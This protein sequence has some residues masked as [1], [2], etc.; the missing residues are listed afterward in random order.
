MRL[1]AAQVDELLRPF[2]LHASGFELLAEG[3]ANTNYRVRLTDGA[4]VVLR[5]HLR[6]PKAAR[7]E[8]VA[9]DR[10]AGSLPVA[11]VLYLDPERAISIVE[12]REGVSMERLL[13]EGRHAEVVSA[14]YDLG[15]S[16]AR[17][18]HFELPTAGFLDDQLD[19]VDPWP[20]AVD[21]LL[22]YLRFLLT[23]P[24]AAGRLGA[25]LV[26]AIT[27]VAARA[28][29]PLRAHSGPPCLVHGD[30]KPSNLLLHEGR[31]SAVLDWEFAHAGTW[32]FHL[33]QLFRHPLPDGFL[34]RFESGL[35]DG[36]RRLPPDWL[37]LVAALDMVNLVDFAT[38]ENAGERLVADARRLLEATVARWIE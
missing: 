24:L 3:K 34:A 15:M 27:E 26:A 6:E 1:D 20:S 22:G 32:L 18:S 12:W 9:V 31:L 30:Y 16:V 17:I 38:G 37:R 28:E 8:A 19:V 36:G 5:L 4:Q 14:A 13:A 11:R 33:A 2:G 21:G 25:P 7:L 35:T 23:R 29:I 10:V